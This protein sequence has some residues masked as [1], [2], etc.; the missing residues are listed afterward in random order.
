ML[1]RNPQL[2]PSAA[3][4]LSSIPSEN[5]YELELKYAVEE[6]KSLQNKLEELLKQANEMKIKEEFLPKRRGSQ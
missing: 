3:D 6:N 5:V 1:L 4:L 2:R